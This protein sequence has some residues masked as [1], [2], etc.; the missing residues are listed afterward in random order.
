MAPEMESSPKVG[1]CQSTELARD[2]GE[3]RAEVM[4]LGEDRS[5]PK[6]HRTVLASI[7]PSPFALARTGTTVHDSADRK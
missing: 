1:K 2:D 5:E 3:L 7:V 4:D 6:G